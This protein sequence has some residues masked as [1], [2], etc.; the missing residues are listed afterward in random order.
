MTWH[1]Q[2]L[3]YLPPERVRGVLTGQDVTARST[4]SAAAPTSPQPSAGCRRVAEL[5]P[6]A[7]VSEQDLCPCHFAGFSARLVFEAGR[8]P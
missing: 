2:L 8:R 3:G 1:S 4:C 6:A 7:S 5:R